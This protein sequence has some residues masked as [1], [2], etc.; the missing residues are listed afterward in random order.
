MNPEELSAKIAELEA[1]LSEIKAFIGGNESAAPEQQPEPM[2][3]A[4][5]SGEPMPPESEGEDDRGYRVLEEELGQ[6]DEEKRGMRPK[7]KPN[8]GDYAAM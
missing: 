2:P 5:E 4:P 1:A 8:W 7:K 3:E 6:I